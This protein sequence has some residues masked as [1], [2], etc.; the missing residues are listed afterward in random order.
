MLKIGL[1]GGIACG[2]SMVSRYFE[3]LGIPVIDTDI[4]ARNLVK[5]GQPALTEIIDLFGIDILDE[6]NELNRKR[7]RKIIFKSLYK[8]EQL[9]SILH[10]KI[11]SVVLEEIASINHK[12]SN[13]TNEAPPYC[14]IVIPLL[15]ETKL[16]YPIDRIL[17]VDCLEQQQIERSMTRDNMTKNQSL[18]II[19]NQTSR[20]EKLE[21]ADDIIENNLDRDY[22]I[23]QINQIH[24][25]YL[26]ISKSEI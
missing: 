25:K 15:F 9:E 21:K 2:K 3:Q 20:T 1:T 13:D 5:P 12:K 11:H 17:L 7:L 24:S 16:K 19:Q 22:C 4:I 23:T 18:D 8:R 14:I 10:P 26:S 6:N